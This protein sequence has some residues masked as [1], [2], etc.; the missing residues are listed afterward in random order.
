MSKK[1]ILVTSP[2][3]CGKTRLS[4]RIANEL[5]GCVYLDKDSLIPLSKRI[6]VVARKPYNR[7]SVFF[8]R[9][10]RDYEY[11]AILAV[12]TEALKYNDTVILN[13]PFSS[14]LRNDEY[15]SRLKKRIEKVG[16]KL[17]VVWI[18]SDEQT[19]FMNM[20]RRNS[21]RDKWKLNHWNEYIKNVCFAAPEN[22]KEALLI[23]D[24]RNNGGNN[25]DFDRL[26]NEIR[27]F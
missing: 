18:Q 19:C 17:L 5:Y 20:K 8:N 26:I 16:A 6:F 3:A 10:I 13:A 24:G 21:D 9:E 27:Q 11:D 22:L 1:L 25:A 2:P 23:Y 14:E 7:S 15:M 4:K 12:A